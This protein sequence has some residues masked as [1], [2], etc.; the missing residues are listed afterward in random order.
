ML[1]RSLWNKRLTDEV[2]LDACERQ[3]EGLDDP[4]LCLICGHEN[5]C[6]E[7]DARNYTCEACGAP[8]V[9]GAE[10]LLLDIAL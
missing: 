9:F 8:Q 5:G 1:E 7:P 6:C 10:E 3:R 4:G 2:I